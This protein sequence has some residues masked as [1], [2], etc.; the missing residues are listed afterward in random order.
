MLVDVWRT[1]KGKQKAQ[2]MLQVV[3]FEKTLTVIQQS[4]EAI[5]E[6]L[7]PSIRE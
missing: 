1:M 6:S 2:I 4:S 3:D 5:C 7:T